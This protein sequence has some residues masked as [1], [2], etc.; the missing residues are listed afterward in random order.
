MGSA[1]EIAEAATVRQAT[2]RQA[3]ERQEAEQAEQAEQAAAQRIATAVQAVAARMQTM[4]A[5]MQMQAPQHVQAWA[6][7]KPTATENAAMRGR[8]DGNVN[9]ENTSLAQARSEAAVINGA[10]YHNARAKRGRLEDNTCKLPESHS[11]RRVTVWSR[12]DHGTSGIARQL[13]RNG[14]AT[15]ASSPLAHPG[16]FERTSISLTRAP[17]LIMCWP[18]G[19][20]CW[21]DHQRRPSLK[22]RER[23]EM[24]AYAA[25]AGGS[26]SSNEFLATRATAPGKRSWPSAWLQCVEELTHL[27]C[28]LARVSWLP[29]APTQSVSELH[30]RLLSKLDERGLT[31]LIDSAISLLCNVPRKSWNAT[32][33][34][35]TG[36]WSARLRD[37]NCASDLLEHLALARYTVIR[38]PAN[39]IDEASTN[40]VQLQIIPAARSSACFVCGYPARNAHPSLKGKKL[41]NVCLY[42][43]STAVWVEDSELLDLICGACAFPEAGLHGCRKC[44]ASLCERCL[45]A[46][47][48]SGALVQA[49]CHR[50][51]PELCSGCGREEEPDTAPQFGCRVICD[52]CKLEW[53]PACHTPLI[54]SLPGTSARWTCSECVLKG[55]PQT[56]AWT[57]WSCGLCAAPETSD[58]RTVVRQLV[59]PIRI[60]LT[61]VAARSVPEKSNGFD[62]Q[63][64]LQTMNDSIRATHHALSKC[65]LA[66]DDVGLSRLALH[67][68]AKGGLTVVSYCD[69]KGTLLG[70]LLRKGIRVRRYLSVEVNSVCN[71]VCRTLYGGAHDNMDVNALRFFGDARG[72]S[73]AKLKALDCWPVHL[74]AAQTPCEDL[75]GCTLNAEGLHGSKSRLFLD[76]CSFASELNA[77]N[78]KVDLAIF[79]ENV[80]PQPTD[81]GEMVRLLGIPALHSEAAVFEA[82]RRQRLLFSNVKYTLVPAETPNILLQSVLNPGA[83]A[84][85]SKANCIITGT[86]KG[87]NQ[88]LAT[89]KEHS[90]R[91]RGRTLVLCASHSTDVRGLLV[92]EMARALGQPDFEVD[93]ASGGESEKM[94]LLGRSLAAGQIL[95][96]LQ[97]LI[98]AVLVAQSP[99][100]RG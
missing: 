2:E 73:T 14:S 3:T 20:W 71:R 69:G 11:A 57:L 72:L 63:A 97:T 61:G 82:A 1:A 59:R 18:A 93:S 24:E 52:A 31:A 56:I 58:V 32:P 40:A 76:F 21:G 78:G 65:P 17:T 13:L 55:E 39:I 98:E 100:S 74:L 9:D 47:H 23:A 36:D 30:S 6:D 87:H 64:A 68:A 86:I 81:E 41:C 16:G 77:D 79:A 48:G 4:A 51:H 54:T 85:A 46:L 89:A 92:Q 8:F 26:S 10:K 33:W 62:H 99:R 38:W 66:L 29:S 35:A 84:L 96:G 25:R 90:Q 37:S 43:H 42:R 49:R 34:P 28:L 91:N 12:D 45:E 83:V 70:F 27:Q 67:A 22:A 60:T 5:R 80:V 94:A 50:F 19:D 95:H 7:A 44:G 15:I 75:S 88:S 53:H